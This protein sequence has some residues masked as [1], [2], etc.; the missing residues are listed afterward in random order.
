MGLGKGRNSAAVGSSG[1]SK[2]GRKKIKNFNS[3]R[4]T[5]KVSENGRQVISNC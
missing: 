5:E 4:K 1:Q 2:E 3:R